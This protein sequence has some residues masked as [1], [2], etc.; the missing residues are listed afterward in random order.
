MYYCENCES[1]FDDLDSRL[2]ERMR[3]GNFRCPECGHPLEEQDEDDLGTDSDPL[4]D[5]GGPNGLHEDEEGNL[6][7]D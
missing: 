3:E 1:T 5:L 2:D 4:G 6:T 7:Y